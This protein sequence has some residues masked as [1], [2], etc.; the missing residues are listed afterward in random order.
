VRDVRRLQVLARR[1]DLRSELLDEHRRECRVQRRAVTLERGV[2]DVD[3][4]E[5][6]R[7]AILEHGLVPGQLQVVRLVRVALDRVT[8]VEE[9]VDLIG[10]AGH[11]AD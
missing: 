8:D 11:A 5:A 4:L 3:R 10:D 2:A 6:A 9:V 1:V 7:E